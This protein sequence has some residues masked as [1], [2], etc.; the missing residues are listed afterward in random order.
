MATAPVMEERAMKKALPLCTILVLG[1]LV[2]SA[3]HAQAPAPQTA[4]QLQEAIFAP[5]GTTAP[6]TVPT[7]EYKAL[8]SPFPEDIC[9]YYQCECAHQCSVCGGIS[10]FTCDSNTGVH[11]CKCRP[12]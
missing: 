12:C 7:P 4:E 3:A 10:S 9:I 2:C 6:D 11:S 5:A 8:C 1:M